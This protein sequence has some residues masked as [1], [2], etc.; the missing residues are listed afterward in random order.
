MTDSRKDFRVVAYSPAC[1]N[2]CVRILNNFKPDEKNQIEVIIRP[3][4]KN[5]S[6]EQNS[7]Y[8]KWL[9]EISLETGEDTESLHE[10]FKRKFLAPILKRDDEGYRDLSVELQTL[11]GNGQHESADRIGLIL[12]SKLSTGA[13]TTKQFSE[14]LDYI[15]KH[16]A[17][18]LNI[19]LT[20]P[21]TR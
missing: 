16:A 15:E 20:Q 4:R 21:P 5:R 14:Y 2:R 19:T 3:Y 18:F 11:R 13:L 10:T 12:L 7:L 17:E 1:M 9:G 6:R 8:W